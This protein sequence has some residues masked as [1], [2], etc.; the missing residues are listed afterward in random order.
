MTEPARLR[1]AIQAWGS[2]RAFHLEMK[3]RKVRGS[4]Y[5]TIHSYL[6]GDTVPGRQFMRTAS[7]VLEVRE[8]WLVSGKGHMTEEGERLQQRGEEL[9][10]RREER[11][12]E[13]RRRDEERLRRLIVDQEDRDAAFVE[14]LVSGMSKPDRRR[15]SAL[16]AFTRMLR[17]AEFPDCPWGSEVARRD[18]LTAA[19]K[20]LEGVEDSLISAA[21]RLQDSLVMTRSASHGFETHWSD[22]VLELF[23]DRVIGL[24]VRSGSPYDSHVGV[25]TVRTRFVEPEE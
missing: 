13:L 20:F 15:R 25:A 4:S 17:R 10:R 16:L 3:K 2:I 12:E 19:H 23:A 22:R 11:G 24:G 8:G 9:R 14:Q 6:K 7:E 18:L 21:D 1:R 5:P